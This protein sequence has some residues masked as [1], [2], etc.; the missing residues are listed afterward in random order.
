MVRRRFAI[1]TRAERW[2][3]SCGGVLAL[4]RRCHSRP[5]LCFACSATDWRKSATRGSTKSLRKRPSAC[6]NPGSVKNVALGISAAVASATGQTGSTEPAYSRQGMVIV[7][8]TS[9]NPRLS[10]RQASSDSTSLASSLTFSVSGSSAPYRPGIAETPPSLIAFRN[11][12]PIRER[13]SPAAPPRTKQ[14]KRSGA[15]WA[16]ANPILPPIEYPQ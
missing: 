2:A 10:T 11:P 7:G 16:K 8:N 14:R 4:G 6:P 13:P 12:S 3:I 9:E 1:D 5:P 15:Y